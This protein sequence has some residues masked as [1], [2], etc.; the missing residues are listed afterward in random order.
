MLVLAHRGASV[1]FAENTM[2]AFE[3]AIAM[4][5]DGVELDVRRTG[6]MAL[7][8]HHDEVLA[9]ERVIVDTRRAGLPPRVPSLSAAPAKCEGPSVVKVEHMNWQIGTTSC[10]EKERQRS[11]KK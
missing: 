11:G 6:D 9:D 8:V 1:A 5:A 3:G 2:A 4:G 7:A 10:R